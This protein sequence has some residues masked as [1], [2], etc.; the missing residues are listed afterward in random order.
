MMD[1]LARAR[2]HLLRLRLDAIEIEQFIEM[3]ERFA[4]QLPQPLPAA[5][6]VAAEPSQSAVATPAAVESVAPIIEPTAP[7][8]NPANPTGPQAKHVA[9]EPSEPEGSG[10]V[11]DRCESTPPPHTEKAAAAPP[12][13]EASAS[14]APTLRGRMLAAIAADPDITARGLADVLGEPLSRIQNNLAANKI[15]L[16]KLTPEEFRDTLK[17]PRPAEEARPPVAAPSPLPASEQ[18]PAT[19][20][21][22]RR[23]VGNTVIAKPVVR[24][25]GTR[26]YLRNEAG[27]FLHFSCGGMTSTKAHAWTGTQDQLVGC[28][29]AFSIARDLAEVVVEKEQRAVA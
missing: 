20:Y 15:K 5:Q 26:F 16:R 3:Y 14:P 24:P 7:A 8:A 19:T 22:E 21:V 12:A 23:P 17:K 29:K 25:K 4:A 18:R 6:T 13:G 27:E 10:G 1:V 9:E 28:R 2:N 11:Q